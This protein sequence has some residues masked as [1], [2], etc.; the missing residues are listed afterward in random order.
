MNSRQI[1]S[2]A[3]PG[4]VA[5][6]LPK[7][8]PGC[9]AVAGFFNLASSVTIPGKTAGEPK[10]EFD[11]AQ[12]APSPIII[13][14]AQYFQI[15]RYKWLAGNPATSLN[16]PF[17]VVL[18]AAVLDRYV[19]EYK[20]AAVGT[21]VTV[22][23]DGDKLLLKVHGAFPDE[24][25]FVARSETRFAS[26]PTTTLEFQLDGQGKVTG[27]IWGQGQNSIPLELK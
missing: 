20:H 25:P 13:T 2:T 26:A 17:R 8:V 21:M 9:E 12:G 14:D 23:R 16:D 15:F 11:P 18:S 22:R 3:V 1:N 19:G 7:E 4:P 10:K 6:T 5:R 24:S 27:V